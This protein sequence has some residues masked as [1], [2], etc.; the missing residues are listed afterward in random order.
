MVE[1]VEQEWGLG[2]LKRVPE[3]VLRRGEATVGREFKVLAH[4]E[5]GVTHGSAFLYPGYTRTRWVWVTH[6]SAST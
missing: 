5:R 3:L 1:W 4:F 6:R 2:K